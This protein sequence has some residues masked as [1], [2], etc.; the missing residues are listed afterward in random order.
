[1]FG[2]KR[3]ISIPRFYCMEY[4]EGN[5]K[6]TID[7]DFRDPKLYLSKSLI[8]HWDAPYESE[9][10]PEEKRDEIYRYIKEHLI[11]KFG[12]EKIVEE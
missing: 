2:K 11:K 7:M 1:M 6:M 10:L 5:K 8:T 12:Q 9:D 4:S 3:H